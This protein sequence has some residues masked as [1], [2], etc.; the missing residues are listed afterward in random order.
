MFYL[1]TRD[2]WY[3]HTICLVFTF[4]D[5]EDDIFEVISNLHVQ[6]SKFGG[7]IIKYGRKSQKNVELHRVHGVLKKSKS[8]FSVS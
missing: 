8:E 1:L 4:A 3:Y 6:W 5:Y 2:T 7:K